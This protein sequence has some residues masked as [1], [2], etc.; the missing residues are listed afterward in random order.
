MVIQ[1]SVDNKYDDALNLICLSLANDRVEVS[2]LLSV[3]TLDVA[4]SSGE[5][6]ERRI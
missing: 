1:Y 2:D 3:Y 4:W 6:T 5:A